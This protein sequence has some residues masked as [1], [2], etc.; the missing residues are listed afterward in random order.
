MNNILNS[1][2][3][4][5]N[6]AERCVEFHQKRDLI[7]PLIYTDDIYDQ[8]I[9]HYNSPKDFYKA[10][11]RLVIVQTCIMKSIR[12]KAVSPCLLNF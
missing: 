5:V 3:I 2:I 12:V 9:R 11:K 4:K 10:F 6:A 7:I 1:G 8:L